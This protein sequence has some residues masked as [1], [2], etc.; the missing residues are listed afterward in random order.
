MTIK[1]IYE[2]MSHKRDLVLGVILMPSNNSLNTSHL[3]PV[4]DNSHM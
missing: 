1:D 3:E 4:F 2:A